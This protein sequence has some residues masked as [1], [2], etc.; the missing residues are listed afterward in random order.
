MKN[1]C[2]NIS[3]DDKI[4]AGF[5]NVGTYAGAD[6]RYDA[7]AGL[8]FENGTVQGIYSS[9]F[10]GRLSQSEGVAFLRE[11]RRVLV[12]GGCIR[13]VTQNLDG[14]ELVRVAHIAGLHFEGRFGLGESKDPHYCGLEHQKEPELICEF[15]KQRPAPQSTVPLV[16]ILIPAYNARY[17]RTCL[18]SALDQ[19]YKN[20]EIVVCNDNPASDEIQEIVESYTKKDRRIRY[21]RNAENLGGRGRGNLLRCFEL[22]EGTYIKFLN[23]DDVLHPE[24]IERMANFL[25]THPDVTL[26]TSA[27]NFMNDADAVIKISRISGQDMLIDGV[28]I[29][30]LMLM[31]KNNYIGEP[32]TVLFRKQD[33]AGTLP[34]I[35]SFADKPAIANGDVTMWV[36]LL[37]KGDLIFLQEPLSSFRVHAEQA[38]RSQEYQVRS[39]KGWEQIRFDAG[40]MGF[41]LPPVRKQLTYRL[42]DSSTDSSIPYPAHLDVH[43]ADLVRRKN[44]GEAAAALKAYITTDPDSSRAHNDL[45]FLYA[46]LGELE[47]AAGHYGK[48]LSLCP[49]KLSYRKQVAD[50]FLNSLNRPDDALNL[51]RTILEQTPGDADL[52]QTMARAASAAGRADEAHGY[53]ER[54]TGSKP[55]ASGITRTIDRDDTVRLIRSDGDA[56]LKLSVIIPTRD[57]AGLLNASLE[58]LVSQNVPRGTF[59]VIVVNDG[60]TDDTEAVCRSFEGRLAIRCVTITASGI[61]KAKNVG[62][63]EARGSICFFFD[64]DDVADSCLIAEHLVSHQLNPAEA[65]A[66]LGFTSW[67]STLAISPVMHYV[68]DVGQVLFSYGKLRNGQLLD[69]RYFWGGRSSCKKSFLTSHGMFRPEFRFGYEDIELGYRLDR[70][71]LKVVY[72]RNAIS[73]MN[74]SITFEDF[75]KRCEKQ[76]R[77]QYSFSK[78]H[79]DQ[80]IQQYC[81]RPEV[82]S[83]WQTI[84]PAL[85]LKIQETRDLEARISSSQGRDKTIVKDL[86]AH[87]AWVFNALKIK[88]IVEAMLSDTTKDPSLGDENTASLPDQTMDQ[89]PS[90][91]SFPAI[92]RAGSPT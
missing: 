12:N 83:K 59:E 38:Q 5:I 10:I 64:D 85:E 16:S 49:D 39:D 3:T 33:L 45:A 67:A 32:S 8:P 82:E 61:A 11:C 65:M 88:G 90:H 89:Q 22:A 4:L 44:Y 47:A 13:A 15:T 58:S 21:Y 28:S 87:Y 17:L 91:S 75:C 78:M 29:A 71:G 30:N 9:N 48:A 25:M 55:L 46:E 80:V 20:L 62:V 73:Y 81:M 54:L 31:N 7:R 40:R 57:R 79:P 53:G 18:N 35:L 50:F 19:T 37:S 84:E 70:F 77:S 23:D 52:L 51:Y 2:L 1:C 60:S 26:V 6:V 34:D 63:R 74:R 86:H 72:N 69:F 36:S 68:T 76:G 56:E 43:L 27:R 66:V 14:D 42:L 41:L 24:C 92:S